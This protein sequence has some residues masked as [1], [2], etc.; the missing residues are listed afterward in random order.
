MVHRFQLQW[1]K[2]IVLKLLTTKAQESHGA[3]DILV[4]SKDKSVT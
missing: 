4:Y 3:A 2:T 1:H